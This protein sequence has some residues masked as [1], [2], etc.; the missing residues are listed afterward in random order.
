MIARYANEE[1]TSSRPYISSPVTLQIGPGLCSYY[2]SK[3]LLKNPDWIAFCTNMWTSTGIISLPDLDENIGHTLVHYL[4][5]GTYETINIRSNLSGTNDHTEFKQAVSVC[6][7]AQTYHLPG[8]QELARKEANRLGMHLDVFEAVD[9]VGQ[10]YRKFGEVMIWLSD[11][12]EEKIKAAFHEDHTAFVKTPLLDRS[13]NSDLNSFLA[14]CVLNLYSEKISTLLPAEHGTCR[15]NT[16][17]SV[18]DTG[19]EYILADPSDDF[20]PAESLPTIDEKIPTGVELSAVEVIHLMKKCL[21]SC[22]PGSEQTSCLTPASSPAE[23]SGFE[24]VPADLGESEEPAVPAIGG[25]SQCVEFD[26]IREGESIACPYRAQHL[27]DR[28]WRCCS[29]CRAFLRHLSSQSS[30]L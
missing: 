13:S 7:A 15:D 2:V 17:S 30:D 24:I 21:Q 26:S 5:T 18:T 3:D 20:A 14:Q 9:A 10:N 28:N 29:Q 23:G 16:G 12:L 6:V 25:D 22:P 27:A 1:L 19:A 8:L 4:Y 11:Y